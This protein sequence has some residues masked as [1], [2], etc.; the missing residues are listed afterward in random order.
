M[1]NF[2]YGFINSK[3]D[4]SE[5]TDML[6][7]AYQDEYGHT[8][9]D[10][11]NIY[12]G[13]HSS[14]VCRNDNK[15]IIG[16]ISAYICDQKRQDPLPMERD[17]I[18]LKKYVQLNDIRYAQICRVAVLKEWRKYHILDVLMERC[19][20]F[21]NKIKCHKLFWTAQKFHSKLYEMFFLQ[22][23][24]KV[25]TLDKVKHTQYSKEKGA[26]GVNYY[27]SCCNISRLK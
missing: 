13:F 6:N 2:H 14:I 4:E 3:K 12:S 27:L 19:F 8:I 11:R 1:K 16:G 25:E 18:N 9:Y 17:G 5:Y 20:D 22:R 15:R 10:E 24:F 23:G 26:I 7:Q 21:C